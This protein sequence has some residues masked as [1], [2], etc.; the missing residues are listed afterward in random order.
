MKKRILRILITIAIISIFAF[1]I[2]ID[3]DIYIGNS[4]FVCK[5]GGVDFQ[6]KINDRLV[7]DDT[8]HYNPFD[9]IKIKEK[10]R[11]G[12]HKITITSKKAEINQS[13]SI[14]LFVN[15][16]IVVEFIPADSLHFLPDD[17]VVMPDGSIL[18]YPDTI[19]SRR[20]SFKLPDG[21]LVSSNSS[22]CAN[23][24]FKVRS[25]FKPFYY[26]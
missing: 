21:T 7:F 8:I 4:S 9:Y 25:S 16:Y 13:T 23:S 11:L 1:G 18:S 2:R 3:R 26:E 20:D 6:M 5:G 14:F 10:L 24:V 17:T 12:R 19:Y 15:Q 22:Y